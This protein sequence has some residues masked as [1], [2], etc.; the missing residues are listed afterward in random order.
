MN[1]ATIIFI[2]ETT[3][4]TVV[5]WRVAIFALA[6]MYVKNAMCHLYTYGRHTGYVNIYIYII[7][8]KSLNSSQQL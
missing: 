5:C 2:K 1:K 8:E 4:E 6:Y 7:V 3:F